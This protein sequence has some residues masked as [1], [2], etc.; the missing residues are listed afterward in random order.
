MAL[1]GNAGW[2][3]G[4]LTFAEDSCY[5]EDALVVDEDS[6]FGFDFPDDLSVR[7]DLIVNFV[8]NDSENSSGL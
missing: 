6:M 4:V 5:G 7:S 3:S 2:T 1:D 8:S